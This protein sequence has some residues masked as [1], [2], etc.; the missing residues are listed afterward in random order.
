MIEHP[1]MQSDGLKMSTNPLHKCLS[2]F[3]AIFVCAK[4]LECQVQPT[5]GAQ[6]L[7]CQSS[8]KS[9]SVESLLLF[10]HMMFELHLLPSIS[11]STAVIFVLIFWA[12][13]QSALQVPTPWK[14]FQR[15]PTVRNAL[16]PTK[17]A[18]GISCFF[19]SASITAST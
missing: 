15:H 16:K 1:Q 13:G 18:F 5:S 10:I 4:F 6:A 2:P 12:F 9:F 19:S 14:P 7:S 3:L 8:E 17:Q 11:Q